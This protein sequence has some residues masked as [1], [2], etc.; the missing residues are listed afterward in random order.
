MKRFLF[1]LFL[2]GFCFASSPGVMNL[3][4]IFVHSQKFL[5]DFK[6]ITELQDFFEEIKQKY[7][8]P[9]ATKCE[10]ILLTGKKKKIFFFPSK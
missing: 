1:I 4:N 6:K 9:I 3:I 5:E 7:F 2:F 8:L 10:F